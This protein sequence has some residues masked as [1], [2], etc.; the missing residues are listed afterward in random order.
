VRHV[1][2]SAYCGWLCE[3]SSD[4]EPRS[5]ALETSL[6]LTL[7]AALIVAFVVLAIWISTLV[8][9]IRFDVAPDELPAPPGRL[10][11]TTT[12]IGGDDG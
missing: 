4:E 1:R 8:A 7:A 5:W 9:V 3:M 6:R 10:E 2:R 12:T 11:E